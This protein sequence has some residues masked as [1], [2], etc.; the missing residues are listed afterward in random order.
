MGRTAE[1]IPLG[2]GRSV[3]TETGEILDLRGLE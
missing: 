3:D 1:M 2:G